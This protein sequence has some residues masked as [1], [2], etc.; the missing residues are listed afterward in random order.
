MNEKIPYTPLATRLSSSARE[1]ELRLRNIFSGPRKRPP[2]LFLALMFSACIFCGNLVSCQN[3]EAESPDIPDSPVNTPDPSS[4]PVPPDGGID[5]QTFEF[6]ATLNDYFQNKYPYDTWYWSVDAPDQPQE[7]D[8][9]LGPVEYLGG[10]YAGTQL[11][12]AYTVERR[13]YR[14]E[15][16]GWTEPSTDAFV[17]M[18][19]ADGTPASVVQANIYTEGLTGEDIVFQ[20]LHDVRPEMTLY[21]D[22][23]PY[24]LGAWSTHFVDYA[25]DYVLNIEPQIEIHEERE[26]FYSEN[27]Y[28]AT[29]SWDGLSA[30]CYCD[31][32]GGAY[33]P[34]MI[35]VTRPDLCTPRGVRVGDSRAAVREAYPELEDVTAPDSVFALWGLEDLEWSGALVYDCSYSENL[36]FFFEG[37]TLSRM[38]LHYTFD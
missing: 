11:G 33:L 15:S 12:S 32:T 25:V 37:D 14:E 30:V 6:Y 28:W 27:D 34:H 4:L 23:C 1:T 16:G 3:A 26:P 35:E 7:W 31:G 29:L 10:G 36:L 21:R 22:G 2:A 19:G 13:Y 18:R 38:V 9:R 17:L 8:I 24:P 20:V 5:S